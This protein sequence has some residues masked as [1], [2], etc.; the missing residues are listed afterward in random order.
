MTSVVGRGAVRGFVAGIRL[1]LFF[2]LVL[3]ALQA[4]R[5]RIGEVQG[6]DLP[7]VL[8]AFVSSR[9]WFGFCW[10]VSTVLGSVFFGV[11]D[12]TSKSGTSRA[13][14]GCGAYLVVSFAVGFV[15]F[16]LAA[17]HILRPV[18][19]D[20]S[21]SGFGLIGGVWTIM[22]GFAAVALVPIL[23]QTYRESKSG[24]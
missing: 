5:W 24:G 14:L 20:M 15:V 8:L 2:F 16:R 10:G 19:D 1:M 22:G 17:P 9:A 18:T 21:P 4:I 12:E 7:S 6:G 3:L 23:L 11:M 13:K